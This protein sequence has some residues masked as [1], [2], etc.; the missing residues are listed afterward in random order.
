MICMTMFILVML[1]LMSVSPLDWKPH[2]GRHCVSFMYQGIPMPD[3]EI[4]YSRRLVN[5]HQRMN[6]HARFT[7]YD[8]LGHLGASLEAQMG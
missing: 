1:Y 8:I 4:K 7:K 3:P 5:V 6:K 2:K